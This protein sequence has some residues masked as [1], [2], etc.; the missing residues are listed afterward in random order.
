MDA[1]L[2]QLERILV[3]DDD[4]RHAG[5]LARLLGQ[6]HSVRTAGSAK[7]ALAVLVR[8]SQD[9]VI[10]DQHMP[11]PSGLWLLSRVKRLFPNVT[12]VL[13]SGD[14]SLRPMPYYNDGIIHAF[15]PKPIDVEAFMT[16]LSA[17]R[18]EYTPRRAR[19]R[20]L[21]APP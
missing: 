5:C 3:V 9:V 10:T 12:R 17:R 8:W 11:G 7:E 6:A 1:P 21:T 2:Q 16:W 13:M 20:T 4:V 18:Y 15:L 14:P 19:E